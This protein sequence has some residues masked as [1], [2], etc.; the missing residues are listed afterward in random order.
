VIIVEE[1]TVD[2]ACQPPAA[3]AGEQQGS[4][5]GKIHLAAHW[6]IL[7]GHS[8][9]FRAKVRPFTNVR[10]RVRVQLQ[11]VLR[12]SHRLAAC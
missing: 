3:E 9:Y 4:T 5:A 7:W 12:G 1:P 11:P 2:M 6:V 8:A 10:T